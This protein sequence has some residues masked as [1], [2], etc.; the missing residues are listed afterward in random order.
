MSRVFYIN[1]RKLVELEQV[2]IEADS[3]GEAADEYLRMANR[4]EVAV[5]NFSWSGL[6]RAD[7]DIEDHGPGEDAPI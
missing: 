1:A 5:S 3:E 7:L 4:G 2:E 6:D